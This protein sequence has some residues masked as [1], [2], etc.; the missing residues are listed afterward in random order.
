MGVSHKHRAIYCKMGYRTDVPVWGWVPREGIA[1]FWG[2]AD[3]PEN[4]QAIKDPQLDV[5]GN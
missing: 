1:P 5:S 2:S 4:G 3:L